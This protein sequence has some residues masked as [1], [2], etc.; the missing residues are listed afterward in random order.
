MEGQPISQRCSRRASIFRHVF[1]RLVSAAPRAS[2]QVS[3]QPH[4]LSW[5]L[6]G[7]SRSIWLRLQVLL[8]DRCCPSL[9]GVATLGSRGPRVRNTNK[10]TGRACGQLV[11][12]VWGSAIGIGCV[13]RVV[14]RRKSSMGVVHDRPE[15]RSPECGPQKV[16]SRLG[17]GRYS[18]CWVPKFTTEPISEVQRSGGSCRDLEN[19]PRS[20]NRGQTN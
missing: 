11:G 15:V 1:A 19:R 2:G 9:D 4:S 20:Q 5:L 7:K 18:M 16:R 10:N 12:Q 3:R 6:V 17:L 14:V 13:W 8:V